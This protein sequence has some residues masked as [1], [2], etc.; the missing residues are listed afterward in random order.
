MFKRTFF[1]SVMSRPSRDISDFFGFDYIHI[2]RFLDFAL[3]SARNDTFREYG[4][5]NNFYRTFR[6]RLHKRTAVGSG[7]D[8]IV[9]DDDDAPVALRP[10]QATNA[11]SKF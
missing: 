11:L 3:G 4:A 9:E 8:A 10:N 2:Q 1:D 7:D 5:S 6:Q